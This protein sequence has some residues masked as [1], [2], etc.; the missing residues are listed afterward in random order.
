MTYFRQPAHGHI[1]RLRTYENGPRD[2]RSQKAKRVATL[3]AALSVLLSLQGI[4]D[5][6]TF[7]RIDVPGAYKSHATGI[8]DSGLIAGWTVATQFAIPQP[9]VYDGT[10]HTIYP[11][12]CA[13][14]ACQTYF[15]GI[16]DSGVASGYYNGGSFPGFIYS[17]GVYTTVNSPF[18]SNGYGFGNN[19]AGDVVG[20]GYIYSGGTFTA[21]NYPGA[22]T[23]ST[24]VYDVNNLGAVTGRYSEG[25]GT[26]GFIYDAGVYTSFDVP[27]STSTTSYGINDAGVV[28]GFHW[29]V[30]EHGFIYD[31]SDGSFVTLDYPNAAH[32]RLRGI[33]NAGEIVGR[34]FNSGSSIQFRFFRQRRR[35]GQYIHRRALQRLPARYQSR[36]ADAAPVRPLL[37]LRTHKRQHHRKPGRQLAA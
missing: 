2:H 36:W 7:E 19:N 32:T 4:A 15:H 8:N 1:R 23:D 37:R 20:I 11:S 33:N 22:D 34:Y 27:G 6:Y 25:S 30:D 24:W 16:N 9:F 28:V 13:P 35:S 12:A 18:I 31:P 26:H 21:I 10:T 29:D 17:G 14:S 3:L 5:A